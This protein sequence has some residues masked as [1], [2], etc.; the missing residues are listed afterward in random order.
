[1]AL[2]AAPV[3]PVDDRAVPR[4]WLREVWTGVALVAAVILLVAFRS[5]LLEASVRVNAVIALAAAVL[6]GLAIAAS[7]PNR[8]LS[9]PMVYLYVVGLFHVGLAPVLA[10]GWPVPDFG[11]PYI[12]RWMDLRPVAA[13]LYTVTVSLLFFAVGARAGSF[14]GRGRGGAVEEADA[15]AGAEG[16]CAAIALAAAV[17]GVVG[18]F[19][20]VISRG[21][22]GVFLGSYSDFLEATA[23]GAL[24]QLY[25][26][27]T[28]AAPLAVVA[29]THP[30]ARAAL[31]V[32][33]VFAV[34]AL[35]LGLR[36]V[37][38]FPLASAVAVMGSRRSLTL[39]PL[40][41]LLIGIAVLSVVALSRSVRTTGLA[42]AEQT[43]IDVN[44]LH[45]MAELG[46]SLRP[47]A[48]ALDWQATLD[49][50]AGGATYTRPVERA[51]SRF[52]PWFDV[53]PAEDDV[54]LMNVMVERRVGPIGFSPVAEGVVNFGVAGAVG[55]MAVIGLL[56]GVLDRRPPTVANLVLLAV[57]L[58]P[59]VIQSRNSFV[60]VPLQLGVGLVIW[61]LVFRPRARSAPHPQAAAAP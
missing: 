60:P 13:A 43:P 1:M 27:I 4:G 54:L 20:F 16:R 15:P 35:A 33:A 22:A 58:A 36:G 6:A 48:E 40:R 39:R 59:L 51:A 11:D 41:W 28:L 5:S 31:A 46:Y 2:T 52:L 50:P 10:L 57:V 44:P 53:P 3:A 37:V 21:G 24:P 25:L 19:A 34:A 47:V 9:V 26:L 42:E 8:Y 7:A 14:L 56:L 49:E 29:P 45:G 55:Y 38:L 18:W 17:V 30:R 12:T 61:L 23:S 32:L